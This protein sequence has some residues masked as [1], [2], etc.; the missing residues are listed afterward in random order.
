MKEEPSSRIIFHEPVV[1]QHMIEDLSGKNL[2]G[3]DHHTSFGELFRRFTIVY[4]LVIALL[5]ILVHTTNKDSPTVNGQ[6]HR[7]HVYKPQPIAITV[8]L[9]HNRHRIGKGKQ[10]INRRMKMAQETN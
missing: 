1:E 6:D 2:W 4:G 3:K 8:L 10:E 9:H 7:M 5:F